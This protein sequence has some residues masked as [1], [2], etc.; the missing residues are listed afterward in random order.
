MAGKVSF[1][2][3]HG[4]MLW[5]VWTFFGLFQV[6]TNRYL[7]HRWQ[8]NMWLH[9]LSGAVVLFTTLL[10]GVVGYVKLMFVKDDVHAPMGIAVTS[11]V[12]FLVLSG[13]FARSRLVR[14]IED[15]KFVQRVK[16]CHKVSDS[17]TPVL[18]CHRYHRCLHT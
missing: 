2:L 5:A 8:A 4:A 1:Y 13:V 16:L 18:I 6:A 7:K 12:L 3:I 10:Y 14:A 17:L 15:Q 9:R 11:I